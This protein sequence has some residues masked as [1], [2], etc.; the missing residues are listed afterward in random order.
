M[1]SFCPYCQGTAFTPSH[2]IMTDRGK[3]ALTQKDFLLG[4]S[5]FHNM[6]PKGPDS[7]LLHRGRLGRQVTD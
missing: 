3:G 6:P 4:A 2:T 7:P 1:V 5:A